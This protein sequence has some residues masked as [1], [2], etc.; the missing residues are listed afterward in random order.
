MSAG[1]DKI[2][3]RSERTLLVALLMSAPG[4]LLT[5][6]AAITSRSTTQMADFVRRTSELVATF[7]SWWVFRRVSRRGE[8]AAY[9][10]RMERLAGRTVAI[11]MLLSAVALLAVGVLRLLSPRPGGS[12]PM[13]LV[14]AVLG[15]VANTIF[16][17]RYRG[18]VRRQYDAVIAA[19]QRL[20]QAKAVV[21]L[22]VVAALAMVAL[23]PGHP[24]T[25]YVDALGSMVVAV[26][27]GISGTRMLLPKAAAR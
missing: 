24:A 4:P 14:I 23:L 12:S 16:F 3:R 11:A 2:A 8:D 21:D 7:V 15:L 17:F 26:Y 20:Y 22:C 27:L 18:I 5:A 25:Q 9:R 13:G 19:Q 10:V 1:D 6:I